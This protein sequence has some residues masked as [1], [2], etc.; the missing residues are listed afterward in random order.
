MPLVTFRNTRWG[1]GVTVQANTGREADC[2]A[3]DRY[4]EEHIDLNAEWTVR[5]TDGDEL[6]WRRHADPD[7]PDNDVWTVW[8]RVSGFRDEIVNL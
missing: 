6:C 5:V 2:N 8:T 7:R 1:N 3:K 4:G